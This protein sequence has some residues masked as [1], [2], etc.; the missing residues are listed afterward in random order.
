MAERALTLRLDEGLYQELR[1]EAFKREHPIS[2]VIREAIAARPKSPG[3]LTIRPNP[4]M[5]SDE[6]LRE[7]FDLSASHENGGSMIA[8]LR[9]IWRAGCDT[10]MVAPLSQVVEPV[11]G[12]L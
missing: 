1:L 4:S 10:G 11:D 5:P 9:A 3:P 8:G 6:Q 2:R 12:E 7:W